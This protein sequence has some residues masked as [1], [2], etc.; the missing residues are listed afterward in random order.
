[1]RNTLG[2]PP[3]L[4]QDDVKKWIVSGALLALTEF[5]DRSSLF[6]PQAANVD[7]EQSLFQAWQYARAIPSVQSSP[8][9]TAVCF[10]NR[11]H[12]GALAGP[13]CS[14]QVTIWGETYINGLHLLYQPI[15]KSISK[16]VSNKITIIIIISILFSKSKPK[17]L[18]L[19]Q[20]Q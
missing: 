17:R 16:S 19:I 3:F 5:L 2:E 20:A 4:E 6:E 12:V 9:L 14:S 10:C 15:S 1:M 11:D 18:S 7:I 8:M 13:L